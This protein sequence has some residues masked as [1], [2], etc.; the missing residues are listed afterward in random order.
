MDRGGFLRSTFRVLLTFGVKARR[1]TRRAFRVRADAVI[2]PGFATSLFAAA[3]TNSTMHLTHEHV[4]D[5]GVH[6]PA[7]SN[8]IPI[9]AH[10]STVQRLMVHLQ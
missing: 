3:V 8:S 7:L 4:T 1:V 5:G 10:S 2:W 6:F 9:L